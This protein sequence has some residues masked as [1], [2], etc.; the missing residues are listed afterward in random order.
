[1]RSQD[2][3]EDF[4]QKVDLYLDNALN[5]EEGLQVVNDAK[6]DPQLGRVFESESNFRNMLKKKIKRSTCSEN[7]INSI[8][9]RVKI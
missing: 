6:S 5:T 2:Q 8:K 1:M 9:S 7:L 4:R 3:L